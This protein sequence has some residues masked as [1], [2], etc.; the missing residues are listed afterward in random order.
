MFDKGFFNINYMQ[1]EMNNLLPN[2]AY[3]CSRYA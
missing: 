1:N 3:V 2:L